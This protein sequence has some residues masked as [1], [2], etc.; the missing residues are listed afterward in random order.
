M[1]KLLI[2]VSIL[3]LLLSSALC[4]EAHSG[5]TDSNG[6]HTNHSTGEYHYHHGYSEHSHYD[7]DGDGDAD[8]PYNFEDKADHDSNSNTRSKENYTTTTTEPTTSQNQ[9][10]GIFNTFDT[11]FAAQ[12]AITVLVIGFGAAKIIS[13]K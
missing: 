13:G 12:I 7:I 8:C 5:R 10:S 3:Y 4:A 1:R 11:A 6:G 9:K 2:A